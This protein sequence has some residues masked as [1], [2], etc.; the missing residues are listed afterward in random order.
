MIFRLLSVRLR[1]TRVFPAR[2][3]DPAYARPYQW[4]A[5]TQLGDD[6]AE[7]R[8]SQFSMRGRQKEMRGPG[9]ASAENDGL[10]ANSNTAE[11]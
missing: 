11:M 1:H 8:T 10:R 3:L 6:E 4:S 5:I 2:L 7:F 9:Y